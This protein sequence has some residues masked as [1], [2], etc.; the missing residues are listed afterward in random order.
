MPLD[1]AQVV[2]GMQAYQQML[3]QLLD[4]KDYQDAGRGKKFVKKSGWRKI[5]RAFNLSTQIVSVAIERAPD[6][7]A[8]R[9]SAIVRAIAP[10]GQV[11][12]GDGYC[13]VAEDRFSSDRGNKSK[14]ENDLR[15]TATTRAKNR[16]I[17]DLVGMGEVSAEEVDGGAGGGSAF[18]PE[19]DDEVQARMLRALAFMYDTGTGPDERLAV[20]AFNKLGITFDYIPEVVA[21]ALGITAGILK[22]HIEASDN[23]HASNDS[24]PEPEVVS[25][26]VLPPAPMTPEEAAAEAATQERLANEF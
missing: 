8:Q 20:E 25:G 6:G 15:A 23:P 2:A 1:T 13:D 5:S 22:R 26:D 14:L 10:N 11:S 9:A 17:S 16:A 12:D 7:S 24:E 4:A 3:P 19:A 18:G 21:R